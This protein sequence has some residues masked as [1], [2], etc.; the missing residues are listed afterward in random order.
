MNPITRKETFLAKAGGQSVSTPK[1]ITREEMFLQRIAENGGTG[2][3]ASSWNDL[4]DRPFYSEPGEVLPET[5]VEIDPEMG[6]AAL[7]DMAIHAGDECT[8]KYNGTEYVC[9]CVDMGDGALA[10][11]NWGVLDEENPVDTG[12]PFVLAKANDG[13]GTLVWC[14][15]PLDGSASVTLAVDGQIVKKIENKYL[16]EKWIQKTVTKAV[17]NATVNNC[18]T[19][20]LDLTAIFPAI[21]SGDDLKV[22]DSTII[23]NMGNVQF[24]TLKYLFKD[25]DLTSERK[26]TVPREGIDN[27]NNFHYTFVWV[28]SSFISDVNYICRLTIGNDVKFSVRTIQ[29]LIPE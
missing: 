9:K 7:P 21:T 10:L 18:K 8:I 24:V 5:T 17:D 2:G 27:N 20:F 4:T 23:T 22:E 15:V 28:T 29:A 1:P 25:G 13:N 26:V 12:E 14:V 6:M 19:T 11:G 3:G 16:D